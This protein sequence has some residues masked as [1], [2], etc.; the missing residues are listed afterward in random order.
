MITRTLTLKKYRCYRVHEGKTKS[1]WKIDKL[2]TDCVL[3]FTQLAG[4]TTLF[5]KYVTE[6]I[7]AS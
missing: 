3:S 4:D 1:K 7:N 6:I 2:V 5:L